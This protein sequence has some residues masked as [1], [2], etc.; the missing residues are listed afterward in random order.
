MLQDDLIDCLDAV[1]R[2]LGGLPDAGEAFRDPPLEVVRYYVRRVRLHWLPWVGRGLSVVAVARQPI[3]LPF[4]A[5]GCRQVLDRLA[6]AVNG[7]YPPW[8]PRHGLALGLCAII[9]T[10]EPIRPEDDAVLS[11]AIASPPRARAVP[12]GLFRVNLGQE[13]LAFALAEGPDGLFREPQA[14]ADALCERFRR[15]VPPVMLG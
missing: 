12:L 14:L 7:R 15:F 11:R 13:A 3:D 10:P 5:A 1:I 9:L 6:R 4:T 8:K 2:P